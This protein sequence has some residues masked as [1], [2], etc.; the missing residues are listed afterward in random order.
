M[1][2][3]LKCNLCQILRL[4][5]DTEYN[6]INNVDHLK[7][8]TLI[9]PWIYFSF[10]FKSFAILASEAIIKFINFTTFNMCYIIN[11]L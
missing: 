8:H 2:F 3:P 7:L 4:V 5:L 6:H 9:F 11:Y 1:T 10:F